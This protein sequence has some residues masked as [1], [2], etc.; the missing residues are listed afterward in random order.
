MNKCLAQSNKTR[1]GAKA[2]KKRVALQPTPHNRG[3]KAHP[4]ERA[5]SIT[6][7]VTLGVLLSCSLVMLVSTWRQMEELEHKIEFL[8]GVKTDERI[9]Q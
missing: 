1:T 8:H 4:M 2:T 3:D 5:M 7:A 6:V 9:T